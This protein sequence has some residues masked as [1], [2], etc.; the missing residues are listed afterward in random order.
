MRPSSAKD[1]ATV[2]SDGPNEAFAWLESQLKQAE[3]AHEK[4]W[5]MF[6]IPPGIDSYASIQ[7]YLGVLKTAPQQ[8]SSAQACLS[9]VVPMWVPSWT[10]Q[11]DALLEKYRG[12]VVASFSGHTHVDDFRV[13][14]P[15][16]SDSPFVLIT[17][18]VSPI[19]NQNPSFRTITFGKDGSILDSSV[20]Y[21]TNLIYASK[22][23]PGEWQQEYRFSQAVEAS[24]DRRSW[25][26]RR[27]T[28]RFGVTRT[29]AVIG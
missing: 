13:L 11:V 6:H 26:C 20:Y 27:F 2:S 7:K 14:D 22:S 4:V 17:A 18:A 12:T 28:T 10:A 5:L 21:L 3:A 15:G 16:A 9:G 1:C 23:T 24:T 8:E 25:L 29:H 19:Y